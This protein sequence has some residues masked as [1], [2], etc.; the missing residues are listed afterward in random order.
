MVPHHIPQI[1]GNSISLAAKLRT[2]A[3]SK[4]RSTIFMKKAN[5]DFFAPRGLKVE[6]ATGE[7]LAAKV[8]MRPDAPLAGP[9][10]ELGADISAHERRLR[11]LDGRVAPVTFDVP[12]PNKQMNVLERMSASQVQRQQKKSEKKTRK[13]RAKAVDEIAKNQK[14]GEKEFAKIDKDRAKVVREDQKERS[15][16]EREADKELAKKPKDL[17]KIERKREKELRK[18]D[19]ETEKEMRKLDKETEKV[20]REVVKE[21]KKAQKED[22][23]LK[24]ARKI[25]WIV[26][27]DLSD[28]NPLM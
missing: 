8:G 12:P 19:H 3:V 17:E 22:K 1:V 18:L 27:E 14:D 10:P 2:A 24:Q 28:V 15:K 7:A 6:L 23:E 16:I 11:A 13:D 9:L 4:T 26:V 20:D 25:L 5:S 21:E